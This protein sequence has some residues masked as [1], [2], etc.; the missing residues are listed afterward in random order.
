MLVSFFFFVLHSDIPSWALYVYHRVKTDEDSLIYLC[1]YPYYSIWFPVCFIHTSSLNC[2]Y[3]FPSSSTLMFPAAH[4]KYRTVLKW[5]NFLSLHC[6]EMHDVVTLWK[7]LAPWPMR[8]SKLGIRY[9]SLFV[10]KAES[11]LFLLR[12]SGGKLVY[13][14]SRSQS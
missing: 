7:A 9:P 13:P 10:L 2:W 1:P 11:K 14:Y 4:D 12:S 3:P 5:K 8:H 6:L